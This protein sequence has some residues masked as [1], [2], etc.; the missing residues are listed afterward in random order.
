VQVNTRI[1][2]EFSDVLRSAL[3]QDP[4]IILVGEMRDRETAEIGLRAAMTGHLVLSTLHTN[5]A[6]ATA[7]RLLDMG[8]QGY[9][10]AASLRAVIAQRLVRRVCS[11]CA[12]DHEPDAQARSWLAQALGGMPEGVVFKRGRGCSHCNNTGYRGR[13]G[14]YEYLEP[15]E[16]MALALRGNDAVAFVEA[17]RA[18]AGYRPLAHA[19]LDYALQGTTSLGEVLRIGGELDELTGP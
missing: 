18:S 4:D 17:A 2:L 14:V 16:R 5:D 7:D 19:A 9:L 8:A 11:S 10:I 12:E 13:I 15:D 6:I 3:R 1:G